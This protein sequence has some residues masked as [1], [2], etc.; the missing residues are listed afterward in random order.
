MHA[1]HANHASER[2]HKRHSFSDQE[3]VMVVS[4]QTVHGLRTFVES[5]V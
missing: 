1:M 3:K 5:T 4:E 2:Y